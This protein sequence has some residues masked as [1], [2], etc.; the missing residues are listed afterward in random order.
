[1]NKLTELER[2]V[3]LKLL[4]AD[5][6][7]FGVLRA[8]VETLNVSEREFTGVGFYTEL[9]VPETVTRISAN[10]TF[11]I[12]DVDAEIKG[13]KHGAGFLLYVEV[14]AL[15]M[16]EGYTYDE[17]WPSQ[18]ESFSLTFSK[19]PRDLRSI[20]EALKSTAP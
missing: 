11:K 8:Q 10:A 9:N 19:E 16:L 13:L 18:I 1:M 6:P 14:G 4:N 5:E 20:R 7:A 3:I 12:G 17:K 15:A 2:A